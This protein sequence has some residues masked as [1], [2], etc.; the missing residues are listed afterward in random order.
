[1][2]LLVVLAN[3]TAALGFGAMILNLLGLD[4]DMNSGEHWT[5]SFAIG[6]GALGWL[7]FPIGVAGVLSLEIIWL[8]LLL[9]SLGVFLLFKTRS[10][11][12]RNNLDAIGNVLLI[13]I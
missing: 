10:L 4:K 11:V 12:L 2:P 5:L 3:V 13:F 6:F 7:V 9:G 8:L 1:M